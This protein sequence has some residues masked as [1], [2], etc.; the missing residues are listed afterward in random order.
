MTTTD[1]IRPT[2]DPPRGIKRLTRRFTRR[3]PTG[4]DGRTLLI[5]IVPM[6]LL[7]SV[8]AFVFMERHWQTVTQRLSTA[9]VQDIAAIIDVIETYPQDADFDEIVRIADSR[10]GLSIA[11]EPS[12]SLPPPL[13]K[14]FFSILDSI[15]E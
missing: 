15:L 3:I 12:G 7:Q 14:P 5:I 9:V 13:S 11:I 10:L 4:L 1:T 8:I 2:Y 6:V